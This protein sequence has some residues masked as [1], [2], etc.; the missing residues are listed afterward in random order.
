MN[1]WYILTFLNSLAVC[2]EWTSHFQLKKEEEETVGHL[3]YRDTLKKLKKKKATASDG[4]SNLKTACHTWTS[5]ATGSAKGVIWRTAASTP[6]TSSCAP[7]T[8]SG[9]QTSCRTSGSCGASL[10]CADLGKAS[11][12]HCSTGPWPRSRLSLRMNWR[13]N[14][15]FF[16]VKPSWMLGVSPSRHDTWL[17]GVVRNTLDCAYYTVVVIRGLTE[18][19]KWT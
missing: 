19:M 14:A 5:A 10:P 12:S 13:T 11:S 9:S 4:K 15:S 18:T 2:L 7:G 16:L 1:I 17:T 8:R 6:A 3:L